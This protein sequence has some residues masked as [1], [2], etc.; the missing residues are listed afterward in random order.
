MA[1]PELQFPIDPYDTGE[2]Y[3]FGDVI[4]RRVILWAVHLGD[5]VAAGAGTFVRAIGDGEVVWS[6]TRRGS[7]QRRNW[8]GLI[9][10]KHDSFY[11][12]YGHMSHLRVTKGARAARSDILGEVAE[13]NTPENGYWERPHLH[14]GIYTGPWRDEVLPGWWRIEQFWRTKLRWWHDPR[15]FLR[16]R[17]GSP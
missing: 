7:M 17:D 4:R 16:S 10:V 2:Y 15:M 11:S 5:D 9:V 8:G 12:V 6:E 14:F 1:P 13:G 3:R